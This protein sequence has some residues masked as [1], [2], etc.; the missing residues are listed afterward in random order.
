MSGR[1]STRYLSPGAALLAAVLLAAALHAAQ[2]SPTGRMPAKPKVQTPRLYIFDCGVIKN[3]NVQS[4]GFAPGQVKNNDAVVPCHLIVH[5]R[6]TLMWDT[7]VVPDE[8][9]GTNA[10]GADRAGRPLGPQLAEIGYAPA[11]IMYLALS[12]YHVDHAANANMFKGSTWL[13]RKAERDA[14]FDGK[15]LPATNTKNFSE[16]RNTK[17]IIL[18]KDEYDVFGDGT[19]V[20]KAAVGHT[21]G[22]QV[23]ILKLAKTGTVM[24][25][26]DLYHFPEE[27]FSDKTP[28]F[29]FNREQTLESR[30]M[31]EAYVQQRNVPSWI[32]H[33]FVAYSTR[34][35]SPGYYE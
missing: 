14:M 18:D 4:F 17:A 28:S 3:L 35:K 2:P 32:E 8:E 29:E 20:I 31:I 11:D 16:L 13:V 1:L 21:P 23:L 27:R 6:G 10:P 22:H 15:P 7:G 25:A 24:L 34:K 9:I 12:H 33:D 5:P 26:G 19:V 30:K